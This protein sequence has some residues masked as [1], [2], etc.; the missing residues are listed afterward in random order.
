[1]S[2]KKNPY[3]DNTKLVLGISIIVVLCALIYQLYTFLINL[4]T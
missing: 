2:T 3:K 1:M 4:L